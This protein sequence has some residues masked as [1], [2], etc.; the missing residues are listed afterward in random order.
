MV[1]KSKEHMLFNR[2]YFLIPIPS[3]FNGS[4]IF[5]SYKKFENN[6]SI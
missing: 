2:K 4:L 6:L 1:K 3:L 5:I